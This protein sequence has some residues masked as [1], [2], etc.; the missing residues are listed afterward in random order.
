VYLYASGDI[1]ATLF[2]KKTTFITFVVFLLQMNGFCKYFTA[3]TMRERAEVGWGM[4]NE[5]RSGSKV[6]RAL[7]K[8]ANLTN[9]FD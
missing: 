4:L 2:S 1:D 9:F 6:R 5:T 7:R 8:H 3:K